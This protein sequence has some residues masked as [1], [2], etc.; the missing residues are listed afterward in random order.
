MDNIIEEVS[1]KLDF[2][3][4]VQLNKTGRLSFDYGTLKCIYFR[5]ETQ[6]VEYYERKE[7]KYDVLKI[8]KSANDDN[9]SMFYHVADKENVAE[10]VKWI[11]SCCENP[12]SDKDLEDRISQISKEI[13]SIDYLKKGKNSLSKYEFNENGEYKVRSIIVAYNDI[14]TEDILIFSVKKDL[15]TGVIFQTYRTINHTD[16][17]YTDREDFEISD[18]QK[19]AKTEVVMKSMDLLD[20]VD[21]GSANEKELEKRINI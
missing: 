9:A 5:P 2:A 1:K 13:D 3:S 12:N 18:V 6:S 10:I 20:K 19:I 15:S 4:N 11:K 21:K 7:I 14:V 8:K 16:G 17:V